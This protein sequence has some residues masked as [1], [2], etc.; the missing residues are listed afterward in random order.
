MA[1]GYLGWKILEWLKQRQDT[2]VVGLV[3]HPPGRQRYGNEILS[4]ANLPDHH[5]F[6][7]SVVNTEGVVNTIQSLDADIGVS[8][9]FGYIL[10]PAILSVFSQGVTNLH[11]SYL[12]YNR[13]AYPNVWSIIEQ[14]PAGVTLHYIDPGVDTGDI[15]EQ[16]QVDIE[17]IDT[18]ATLYSK[19]ENAAFELFTTQWPYI[20]A[21]TINRIRQP[22]GGTSHRVHDVEKV[23]LIDLERQYTGR[24]LI[25]LLRARTFPPHRGAYFI[26]DG[27]KV[28]VSV[29]LD[30]EN[31]V[32]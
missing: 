4:T 23:D 20:V 11:P 8:I 6:D 14:T 18:G 10:R 1:N 9:M 28:F 30:Y 7:G 13:G 17:P 25:N 21:G 15:I 3:V 22:H 16:T 5:V 24:E 19:L 27:K 32:D 2:S 31:E 26:Q 12:P 29:K